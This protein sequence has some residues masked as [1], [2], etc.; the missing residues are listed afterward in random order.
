MLFKKELPVYWN[1]KKNMT[2][3]TIE[4]IL[5]Q[6]KNK[7]KKKYFNIKNYFQINCTIRKLMKY[8]YPKFRISSKLDQSG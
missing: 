7:E 5:Y 3:I 1:L 6:C 4:L 2:Y 8:K